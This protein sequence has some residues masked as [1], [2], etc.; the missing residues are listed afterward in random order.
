M[1]YGDN[2][3]G[4]LGKRAG[5]IRYVP[6]AVIQ[7]QHY[8][9]DPDTPHD[10]T[11]KTAEDTWGAPDLAAFHAYGDRSWPTTCPSCGG[12]SREDVRWVPEGSGCSGFQ[13][14]SR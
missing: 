1:Y 3:I 6:E 14:S 9:V 12:T 2:I 5:L 4:E 11:Y 8:T 10:E 7:H 13:S